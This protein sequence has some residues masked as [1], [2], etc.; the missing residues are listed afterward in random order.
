[1]KICE[2]NLIYFCC[3]TKKKWILFFYLYNKLIEDVAHGRHGVQVVDGFRLS[4]LFGCVVLFLF[5][6]FFNDAPCR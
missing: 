4:V 3:T 6:S 5:I 2:K 1:M